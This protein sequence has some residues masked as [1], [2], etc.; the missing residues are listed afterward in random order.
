MQRH[1]EN[2]C[3]FISDN[4]QWKS[5]SVEKFS[6]IVA[7]RVLNKSVTT[8]LW[9]LILIKFKILIIPYP[10]PLIVLGHIKFLGMYT[11]RGKTWCR[12]TFHY[13]DRLRIFRNRFVL[14]CLSIC[15]SCIQLRGRK[16]VRYF[17]EISYTDM[18]WPTENVSDRITF[19]SLPI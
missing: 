7:L 15:S 3:L 6:F 18:L 11:A 5:T 16:L 8:L 14:V 12:L 19:R 2:L 4:L 10:T 1:F 13:I 17:N 9:G